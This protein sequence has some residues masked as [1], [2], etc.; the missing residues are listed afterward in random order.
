MG[1]C[2]RY[3]SAFCAEI[4]CYAEVHGTSAASR[5]FTQ[6]LG[7]TISKSSVQSIKTAYVKEKKKIDGNPTIL[8]VN[9]RGRPLLLGD[10]ADT[11]Q[12]S[13]LQ[14]GGYI[15]PTKDWAYHFLG[16]MKFV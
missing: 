2:S 16:R 12:N 3:S 13:L 4:G 8:T 11:D 1:S 7:E 6:K 15:N 14:Y 10:A 9:K 5:Y